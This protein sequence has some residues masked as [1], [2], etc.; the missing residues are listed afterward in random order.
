MSR[1]VERPEAGVASCPAR[2]AICPGLPTSYL[3]LP[4]LCPF[5]AFLSPRVRACLLDFFWTGQQVASLTI[6]FAPRTDHTRTASSPS[7]LPTRGPLLTHSLNLPRLTCIHSSACHSCVL[8]TLSFILSKCHRPHLN[9]L[10][11]PAYLCQAVIG[12]ASPR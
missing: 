12:R 1:Y 10:F 3:A 4:I 8:P 7:F 11:D 6:C 5:Q 9:N 2:P